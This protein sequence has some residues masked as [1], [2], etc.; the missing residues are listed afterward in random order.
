MPVYDEV[1]TTK[2]GRTM[3]RRG[4]SSPAEDFIIIASK[5]PWWA[6]LLLAVV[7]YIA[8]HAYVSQP[9]AAVIAS[10]KPADFIIP[11]IL[12]GLATFGQYALPMLLVIAGGLS[13]YKS[14][15]TDV[16]PKPTPERGRK[17]SPVSS[18]KSPSCPVCSSAMQRRE[19]KRGANAGNSFWG[20]SDYPRCKG[21]RTVA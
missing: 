16:T 8:L 2:S 1:N 12:R 17:A 18:Q 14:R 19:A 15:K 3:A 9:V 4:K 6:A 5:L 10:G 11:S 21:T 20:C 7:A 13:W